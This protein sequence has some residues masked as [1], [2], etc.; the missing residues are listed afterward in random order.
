MFRDAGRR[1]ME[2]ASMAAGRLHPE[3]RGKAL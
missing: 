1:A 2:Q 3:R